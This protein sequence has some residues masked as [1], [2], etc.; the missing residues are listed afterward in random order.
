[1][2]N[3]QVEFNDMINF[4]KQY[5]IEVFRTQQLIKSDLIDLWSY[6]NI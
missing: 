4:K 3:Y 6:N 5:K 2:K 1:M